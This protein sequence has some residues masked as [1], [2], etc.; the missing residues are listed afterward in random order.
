MKRILTLALLAIVTVTSLTACQN[1]WRGAGA[2][3][4]NV[5]E[6]MQ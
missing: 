6:K 2:D 1:T 3:V 4:E 5:G